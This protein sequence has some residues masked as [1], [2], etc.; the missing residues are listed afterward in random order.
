ML[1]YVPQ[2]AR[3]LLLSSGAKSIIILISRPR[4]FDIRREEDEM[5]RKSFDGSCSERHLEMLD[6]LEKFMNAYP[7]TPKIAQ[8]WPTWLAHETLKDIYHTD[9]HFLNF[10][11]KNRVQIDQSFFFFM[12]DHGPRREGIL[13]TRLGQYENLNPFL[14]V[15]IPSI[16]RDTP[17]HQQLRRKTY[18]LMT[19]F[20]LHAT[21]IDIL[22]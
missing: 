19:N 9:E 16:Y 5:L 6:Y 18:E 1:L 21:L 11:K 22:K 8:V 14:M 4:P 15:L 12:G 17:I 20:D 10:F 7:G 2:A 3:F 13:K